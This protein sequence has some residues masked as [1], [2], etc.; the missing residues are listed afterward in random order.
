MS[1]DNGFL[2]EQLTDVL[3]HEQ[4][5]GAQTTVTLCLVAVVEQSRSLNFNVD[6][7]F[8]V[9]IVKLVKSSAFKAKA[10]LVELIGS[11]A[12]NRGVVGVNLM[13]TVVDCLVEFLRSEDW[14]ARK[15]ASEALCRI[16]EN[17]KD[18]LGVF[19]KD[20]LLIFESR[21]FDKV[22]NVR[23]S[24]NK[25]I[26]VWKDIPGVDD[27]DA[28]DDSKSQNSSSRRESASDGR[29][30]VSSVGSSSTKSASPVTSRKNKYSRSPPSNATPLTSIK[31]KN[32]SNERKLFPVDRKIANLK[33]ATGISCE[34]KLLINKEN[35]AV[36]KFEAKRLFFENKHEDKSTK[37]LGGLKS[38]SRV[39]PFDDNKSSELV[40][41]NSDEFN[42]EHKEDNLSLIRKQLLQI[43]NQQSNLL[44][45]LQRYIGNSQKGIHSLEKRVN[46]IEIVLDEISRDLSVS[47]VK[48]CCNLP[49]AEFLSP[50]FWRRS[51]G[52]MHFFDERRGREFYSKK[53][54]VVNPLAEARDAIIS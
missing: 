15:A 20:C 44:D 10:A 19:K 26:M 3:F 47:S 45:L 27:H 53:S 1:T 40:I 49:G 48:T 52:N 29:F 12:S 4:E 35:N 2:F 42:G 25:M 6:F 30:P 21:K 8:V 11:V 51:E 14:N 37:T 13:K 33:S 9:K 28:S 23:E 43:E 24:M 41:D 50:K 36:S 5:S 18:V 22:K 54:F 39:V 17:E 16:G 7:N 32:T 31:M 34:E 46:G 38:A